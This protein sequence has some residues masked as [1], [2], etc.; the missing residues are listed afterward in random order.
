MPSDDYHIDP[1]VGDRLDREMPLSGTTLA[2]QHEALATD[3]SSLQELAREIESLA[4]DLSQGM[5][6]PLSTLLSEQLL[7]PARKL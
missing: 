1:N 6:P 2:G 5:S 7:K 4:R 3:V